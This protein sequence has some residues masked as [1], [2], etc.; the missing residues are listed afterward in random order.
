M[1]RLSALLAKFPFAILLLPLWKLLF[2]DLQESAVQ[3]AGKTRQ[4]VSQKHKA[5]KLLFMLFNSRLS[6]LFLMLLLFL[7]LLLDPAVKC[8]ASC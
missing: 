2:L 7:F 1:K 8:A 3:F 4:F 5:F 6:L